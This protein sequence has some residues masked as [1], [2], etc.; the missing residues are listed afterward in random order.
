MYLPAHFAETDPAILK[1]LICAHP[2]GLLVSSSAEEVLA[3]PVPFLLEETGDRVMLKA[4]LARA[5]PQWKHIREGA[6]VLVVFQGEE[7]Y[8]APSWYASKQEHGK[9]VPTWN[10]AMVQ[11]RG[12][13]EVH[14]A[15]EWL[16]PQI[17][18]I[19]QTQENPRH[20]PWQV[21]DAPDRF[22]DVQMRGIVGISVAVTELTGKWKVSQNRSEADRAGVV[23]GLS[24]AGHAAMAGMVAAGGARNKG[25]GS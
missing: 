11:A 17:T 9:V 3:N 8:V 25:D 4:H 5:N 22:I 2:L 16:L 6:R 10:Y 21:A 20:E 18:A 24:E 7:A 13:A 1:A 15:P 19:T 12:V 23:S 14:E